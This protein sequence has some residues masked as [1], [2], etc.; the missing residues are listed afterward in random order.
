MDLGLQMRDRE[1]S[2]KD[3]SKKKHHK[4]DAQIY[5]KAN[6]GGIGMGNNKIA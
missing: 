2:S 3:A 5:R 4:F 6:K 1:M